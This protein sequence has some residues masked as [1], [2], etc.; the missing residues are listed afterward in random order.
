MTDLHPHW[1]ATGDENAVPVRVAA[2]AAGATARITVRPASRM[3]AAVISMLL[4]SGIGITA[5]G[6]W[7]ALRGQVGSGSG[8][9]IPKS[10]SSSS[11]RMDKPAQVH[12]I[13]TG[14]SPPDITVRP[15]QQI[16]WYN[17][18]TIPHIL[19]S[20]T[21]RDGSGA[22]LNT[23]AI[24]PGSLA[25]FTVGTFETDKRHAYGSTTDPTLVGSIVVSAAGASSRSSA[26]PFGG[27]LNDVP[28]PSGQGSSGRGTIARPSSSTSS[29][30]IASSSRTSAGGTAASS[31]SA[32]STLESFAPPPTTA[33]PITNTPAQNIA[34]ANPAPPSQAETGP[35]VWIVVGLS[36]AALYAGTRRYFRSVEG[37]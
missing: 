24:F 32:G 26:K 12:I 15:G 23:P 20:Q 9:A 30:K 6:G 1:R 4:I 10:S 25:T 13:E 17:D 7:Q 19:T 35:E 29:R 8:S 36:V 5:V 22:Y 28:L 18:Q 27:G 14:F 33:A 34:P 37:V 11:R 16:V 21:L 31:P 3:P 2:P